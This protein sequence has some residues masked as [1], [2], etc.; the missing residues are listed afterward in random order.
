MHVSAHVSVKMVSPY[1][2]A[3]ARSIPALSIAFAAM[4]AAVASFSRCRAAAAAA[5]LAAACQSVNV[6]VS[7]SV[8]VNMG[9]NMNVSVNVGPRGGLPDEDDQGLGLVNRAQGW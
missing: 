3:A 9:V 4:V 2:R 8:S 7:V 1:A 6:S 5:A